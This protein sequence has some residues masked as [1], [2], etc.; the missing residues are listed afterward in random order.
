MASRQRM[1]K[2]RRLRGNSKRRCWIMYERLGVRSS[3]MLMGY[4]HLRAWRELRFNRV[5]SRIVSSLVWKN[6]IDLKRY[7][8]CPSSNEQNISPARAVFVTRLW[9]RIPENVLSLGDYDRAVSV[10]QYC[11]PGTPGH[12]S[13]LINRFGNKAFFKLFFLIATRLLYMWRSGSLPLSIC[14][15]RS[16]HIELPYLRSQ[17]QEVLRCSLVAP[18]RA[19]KY[20]IL[21]L[22]PSITKIPAFRS[23]R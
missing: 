11:Y 2:A 19:I 21:Y 17:L 22:R 23:R 3:T 18:L 10:R 12:D 15:A 1:N 5:C 6:W 16:Y 8:V 13:H 7:W 14:T 4:V 9:A 20:Q